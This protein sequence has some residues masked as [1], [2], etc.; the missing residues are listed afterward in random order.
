MVVI[1]LQLLASMPLSQVA[2]V[3]AVIAA[4][5]LFLYFTS[6]AARMR[7]AASGMLSHTPLHNLPM[8][9]TV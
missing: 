9:T 8:C 2:V 7:V 3:F 6:A 1:W 5:A 4:V